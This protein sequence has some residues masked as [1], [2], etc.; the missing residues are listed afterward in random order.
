MKLVL[1]LSPI[2][3][4]IIFLLISAVI[5]AVYCLFS[6]LRKKSVKKKTV[7]SLFL[8]ALI[9]HAFVLA[10]LFHHPAVIVPKEYDRY[11]TDSLAEELTEMHKGFY[12]HTALMTSY[13]NINSAGDDGA[14]DYTVNY[15]YWGYTRH[16]IYSDG[17]KEI[18]ERLPGT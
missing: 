10:F 16:A 13:I 15:L 3:Q 6:K 4:T 7:L 14:V 12:G 18:T 9:F 17:T 5:P 8:A 11:I 1:T 2:W